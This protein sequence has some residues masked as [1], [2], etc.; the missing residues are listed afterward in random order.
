MRKKI[1]RQCQ[2][3]HFISV[4]TTFEQT[5]LGILEIPVLL[6]KKKI[7]CFQFSAVNFLQTSLIVLI[8]CNVL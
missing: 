7:W 6:K 5:I 3:L 2:I 8:F 1:I 4:L